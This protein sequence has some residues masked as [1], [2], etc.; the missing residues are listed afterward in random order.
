M[1]IHNDLVPGVFLEWFIK[2]ELSKT[3][4]FYDCFTKI[5]FKNQF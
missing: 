4:Q 2:E 1:N 5:Y 3:K